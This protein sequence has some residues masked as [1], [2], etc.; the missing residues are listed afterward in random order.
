[1]NL[2]TAAETILA[3]VGEPLHYKAITE[4]AI[5]QELIQ[6]KGKTPWESMNAR[7]AVRI[8]KEGEACRF[9]RTAPGVFALRAWGLEPM[10]ERGTARVTH[11][12]T[13]KG[14]R[15]F[16]RAIDGVPASTLT[17]LRGALHALKGSNKDF[18]DPPT[19]V[20]ADVEP[21][22]R[23]L[24]MAIWNHSDGA[25]NPR[26]VAQPAALAARHELIVEDDGGVW[27]LTAEG[28]DFVAKP[29]GAAVRALDAAEGLNKVLALVAELGPERSTNLLPPYVTWCQKHTGMQSEATVR[30][31]LHARLANLADRGLVA[32]VGL[33]YEIRPDGLSWLGEA[34][35]A[36]TD[37]EDAS[38]P[39]EVFE[40]VREVNEQQQRVK[41]RIRE[42]LFEMDPIA[43]E[44]LIKRLLDEMG[45][46]AV[47]VTKPANDKGVDVV[48][49]IQ[50]GITPVVEAIQAK[51]QKGNVGR[52]VLDALRG[53]LYRWNAQR[54]TIITTAGFTKGARKAAFDLGAAPLQ[55]ID[56]DNLVEL[57]VRS[58]IGVKMQPVKIWRFDPEAFEEG[59]ADEEPDATAP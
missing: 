10:K 11:L 24:A 45:Y 4:R 54:G 55:L 52:P 14:L 26:Y 2:I 1:M 20:A 8:K 18:T 39:D 36:L 38:D 22:A 32:R 35:S 43:F 59:E 50:V 31:A 29:Q 3:E 56:D 21:P 7:L 28:K 57:L 37:D 40:L 33:N 51:R 41:E 30:A 34:P 15:G 44:H 5:E 19:W 6:P 49:R 48:G 47:A 13:W 53:S 23:E 9:M 42:A 58:G 17:A 12:P 25:L 46:E 16:L 27:R